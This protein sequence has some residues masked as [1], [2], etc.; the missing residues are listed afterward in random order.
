MSKSSDKVYGARIASLGGGDTILVQ[1][2]S[3]DNIK[4]G[5]NPHTLDGRERHVRLDDDAAI[6]NAV[7]KALTGEL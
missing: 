2:T 4:G 1:Q 5:N 3:R 7:R 6:A